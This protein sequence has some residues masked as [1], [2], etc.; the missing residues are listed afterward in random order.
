MKE[1]AHAIVNNIACLKGKSN[2][3][4][5][6]GLHNKIIAEHIKQESYE[7]NA[8]PH[9]WVFDE[10]FLLKYITIIS[11]DTVT[12]LP[13]NLH[14]LLDNMDIVIWLS[15][16]DDLNKYTEEV[17]KA[18]I[19]FWDAVSKVIEKKPCLFVNMLSAGSIEG[20][21]IRYRKYLQSF[22]DAINVDYGK[23]QKIGNVI[24]SKLNG[25][26]HVHVY[27]TNGTDLTFSIDKRFVGVEVGNLKECFSTGKE[28]E[29]EVPGGEVYTAPL[30]TSAQGILHVKEFRDYG[31]KNLKL[32]FEQ[33]KIVNFEAEKGC[34]VFRCLLEKATGDKDRIAEFGIGIN[35]GMKPMGYR[36]FDEKAL[37]TCHIAIGNNFHLGGVNKASI[38][39]DFILEG[40]TIEADNT[41]IMK[42]GNLVY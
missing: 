16:Y 36:I 24:S 40:S 27:G 6:C 28:C 1:A 32:H 11:D 33:G 29:V 10:K 23:I 13:E 37:G 14:S 30:E 22:V 5:I 4:I 31:I 2:V 19:S 41:L 15:Q 26:K 38:H 8:Y 18:I 7:V 17:R 3:L 21:D 12:I 9:F 39:W 25:K 34:D 20:I 42:E 35:H